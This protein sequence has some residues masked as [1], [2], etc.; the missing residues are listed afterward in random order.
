M[1][2]TKTVKRLTGAVACAMAFFV[3]VTPMTAFAHT[4][5]EA[6]CNCESKCSDDSKNENCPVC[7]DHPELCQAK[8]SAE[9]TETKPE[10]ETKANQEEQSKEQKEE[11]MGP[12]TPN[13]NMKI[14]DDYG[15]MEVGGKQFITVVTKS[16]KYFY[17]II[18]R[19]DQ[20]GENVHF[21]NMVDEADLMALMNED[22]QKAFQE[23]KEKKSTES[24]I[25][26]T[27]ENPV[28]ETKPEVKE[29]K[30]G[31]SISPAAMLTLLLLL[32]VGSFM[33]FKYLKGNNS[34]KH[35]NEPD[36][37]EDYSDEE[38]EDYLAEAED[39]TEEVSDEEEASEDTDDTDESDSDSEA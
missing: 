23:E 10:E 34:D 24:T 18:D 35:S 21:L 16:G 25:K 12:L 39:E 29:E 31:L 17:I 20:G 1:K 5:P 7:K 26:E 19:D 15:S 14:V 9:Q 30:K 32:G 8:D 27:T 3:G 6:E 2:R 22:E 37:D 33:G 11:K 13:G 38:E 28:K 4:G 36:P